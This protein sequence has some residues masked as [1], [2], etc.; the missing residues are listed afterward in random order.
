[1]NRVLASVLLGGLAWGQAPSHQVL[2]P[3]P[4]VES[5]PAAS[6]KDASV[7]SVDLLPELPPLPP[8]RP[9]LIGGT[10]R[11]LDRVRDEIIVQPFGGH[12]LKILFDGRTQIYR[13]GTKVSPRALRNGEPVYV[14][15]VLDEGAVFAK[16]IHVQTQS[17]EGE[18]RGQVLGYDRNNGELTLNDPLSSE[19]VTLRL[20]S[21][22][23]VLRGDQVVSSD[24]L[25]PG[26]L[27]AVKFHP[28]GAGQGLAHEVSILATPGTSFAFVGRVTHLDL[29]SG[30][31]VLIDPR[32]K[33]T[34]E[35]HFDPATVRISSDLQPGADVTIT[36]SFDGTRYLANSMILNSPVR[37]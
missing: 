2:P 18:S 12:S 14:D 17:S 13:G 11:G 10:L 31:L 9:T 7:A 35:I 20:A 8:G 5:S 25:R 34:Y 22:A 6:T 23:K 3:S 21:G 16:S 28:D 19:S 26:A 37:K 15:T 24:D 32:D 27:V 29:H 33:K 1:M 4:A 36:A 30:L